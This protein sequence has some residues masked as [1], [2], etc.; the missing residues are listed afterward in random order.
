[1]SRSALFTISSNHPVPEGVWMP[2]AVAE[3]AAG[4]RALYAQHQQEMAAARSLKERADAAL[5]ADGVAYRRAAA[6]GEPMPEPTEPG[7][8][9]QAAEAARRAK[10]VEEALRDAL[11]DQAQAVA[12]SHGEW[13]EHLR[14]CLDARAV[15]IREV[16]GQLGDLF[17]ELEADARTAR[18]LEQFDGQPRW[19]QIN[20]TEPEREQRAR[21]KAAQVEACRKRSGWVDPTRHALVAALDRLATPETPASS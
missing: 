5:H 7:L 20:P 12:A 10:A 2:A 6:A 15:E 16:L 21:E 14:S 11:G 13:T 8:R 3:P 18:T 1:M 19:L 9:E 17:A 4:A